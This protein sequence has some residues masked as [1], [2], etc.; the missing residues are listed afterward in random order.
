MTI[1]IGSHLH[2]DQDTTKINGKT[3]TDQI[4]TNTQIHL[5]LCFSS[6]ATRCLFLIVKITPISKS[7]L[8]EA[9]LVFRVC[10][11]NI[12]TQSRPALSLWRQS[13]H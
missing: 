6:C 3:K 13:H 10:L 8:N 7:H 4:K 2:L 5:L 11:R 12:I 9:N 1:V